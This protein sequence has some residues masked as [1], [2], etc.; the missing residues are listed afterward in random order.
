MA[1]PVQTQPTQD[2]ELP[3]PFIT[4]PGLYNFRDIGGWPVSNLNTGIAKTR[5]RILYRG[6][7]VYTII[8]AG[9]QK[10]KDIGVEV[11]FDL[12]SVAQ[13]KRAGGVRELEGIK[14]IWVPVFT[15]EQY[16]PEKAGARYA[17]Y[18]SDGTEVSISW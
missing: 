11:I 9:T 15:E 18:S 3:P 8:D 12:R 1:S 10:L 4:V 7:D 2:V 5:S 17:Q 16:S 14:R 6:S 13:I